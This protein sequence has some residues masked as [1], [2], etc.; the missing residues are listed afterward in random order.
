MNLSTVPVYWKHDH[1][2]QLYP[3][4]DLVVVADQYEAYSTDHNEC[5][6]M[7][8]GVF[9]KNDFPFKVYIPAENKIED[10]AMEKEENS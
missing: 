3:T 2:L 9:S 10:S 5:Q 6:V 1:A 7:N 4:P 8:P